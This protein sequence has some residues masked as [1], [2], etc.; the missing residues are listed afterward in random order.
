M[1]ETWSLPKCGV[2]V[3]IGLLLTLALSGSALATN[4]W[5][6]PKYKPG[7]QLELYI[8]SFNTDYGDIERSALSVIASSYVKISQNTRLVLEVPWQRVSVKNDF[9]IDLT[10]SGL[11][12]IYFGAVWSRQGSS[13][14]IEI[15]ARAPIVGEDGFA[16]AYARYTVPDRLEAYLEEATSGRVAF[17]YRYE[18]AEQVT[19]KFLGGPTVLHMKDADTEVLLDLRFETWMDRTKFF[20]GGAVVTRFLLTDE[21]DFAERLTSQLMFAGGPKFGSFQPGLNVIVPLDDDISEIVDVVYGA[22][23]SYFFPAK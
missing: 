22:N 19:V 16:T 9:N 18:T 5:L 8:P 20:A 11:G 3:V 17:G 2:V 4:S 6:N 23:L 1:C 14:I 12:N 13:E 15:G 21:H 10:E 7:V